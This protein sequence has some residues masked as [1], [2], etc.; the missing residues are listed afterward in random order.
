MKYFLTFF[1]SA[2]LFSCSSDNDESIKEVS[3][4]LKFSQN[5]DGTVIEKSDLENTEFTNK[6][7]SKLSISRLRYLISRISLV[8]GAGDTTKFDSYKLI[9]VS[10]PDSLTYALSKKVSEGSYKLLFTFG[11]NNSDNQSGVY[12]DLNSADWN[13]PDMMGGG[14]HFM[15]LDGKYKDTLGVENLYNFHA[16]RAYDQEKDSILDTSF[17]VETGSILLKNNATIEIKMNVA[18]WFKSPND[19]D[20]NEKSIDLMPDF[21]AQKEISENG[22]SGVFSLGAISQ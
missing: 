12:P 14:Y 6:T 9:D 21:E 11:F 19:W 10:K 16:V 8:N 13:V 20:L 3:V 15:Q 1:L 2:L 4:K 18:G 17:G 5:W 7:G 22:K